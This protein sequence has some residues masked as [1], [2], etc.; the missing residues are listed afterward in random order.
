[1]ARH[2]TRARGKRT[3]APMMRDSETPAERLIKRHVRPRD[4]PALLVLGEALLHWVGTGDDSALTMTDDEFLVGAAADG[5]AALSP[6]ATASLNRSRARQLAAGEKTVGG[7]RISVERLA[8]CLISIAEG[9]DAR[10]VFWQSGQEGT[11]SRGPMH[12]AV[13][14]IYWEHRLDGATRAVA[15]RLTHPA[16]KALAARWGADCPSDKTIIRIATHYREK[17][18]NARAKDPRLPGLK[19]RMARHQRRG[20]E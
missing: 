3:P 18:F 5:E 4:W 15:V 11:P 20:R 9:A 12:S 7:T 19:A 6:S 2:S 13:A 17:I 16:A 8:R 14:S 1:M 10:D